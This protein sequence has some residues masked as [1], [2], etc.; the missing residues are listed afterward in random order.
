MGDLFAGNTDLLEFLLLISK[1]KPGYTLS[2]ASMTLV[3]HQTW[4]G[5][6]YRRWNEE[7]REKTIT[8]ITEDIEMLYYLGVVNISRIKPWMSL[9][10]LV[11]NG[12]EA[13]QET[14]SG[15]AKISR[16]LKECGQTILSLQFEW[17]LTTNPDHC[18]KNKIPLPL[19]SLEKL[20]IPLPKVWFK[21]DSLEEDSFDSDE[22]RKSSQD[23]RESGR[24]SKMNGLIFDTSSYI[25]P[26]E[27]KY[28]WGY[29]G[30]EHPVWDF[31]AF[32]QDPT[33]WSS[34]K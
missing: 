12:L 14:Y 30:W 27:G 32:T 23:Q 1:I 19:T 17:A 26:K 25:S 31:N 15:D 22:P 9:L 18:P 8:K 7:N 6:C 33:T 5:A 3:N 4:S 28:I 20:E 16:R 2:T 24:S 34:S 13:L 21:K 10:I 11:K 29:N